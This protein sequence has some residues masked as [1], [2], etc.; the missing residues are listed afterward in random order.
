MDERSRSDGRW[1]ARARLANVG[2]VHPLQTW[3][4]HMLGDVA[5]ALGVV[6]LGQLDAW[7][8]SLTG[9]HLSGSPAA[10][11]GFYLA[12]ALPLAAR[13][14]FP[15]AVGLWVAGVLLLQFLALGASAGNGT[16][17]PALVAS[18]T[19]GAHVEPPW[20]YAGVVAAIVV[21]FVHELRN[22]NLPTL[23]AL[24]RAVAWDTTFV[25][26]WLLGAYLRT[27][28][29]Y[30]SELHDRAV[31]AEHDRAEEARAAVV[32]ERARIA[33]ELHDAIAH[34]VSVMVVQAEAAA[35]VIAADPV[36]ARGALEK[37]QRSGRDALAELRRMVGVLRTDDDAPALAPEPGL[38]GL[39]SLVERVRASGV[40]VEIRVDGDAVALPPALDLSAYRIVQEALTNTLKHAG[41]AQA[42]ISVRYRVDNVVLEICDNGRGAAGANGGGHGLAGMRERVAFFGGELETGGR[43]DGGFR[44]CAMLPLEPR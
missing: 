20:A 13:R 29:L 24:A 27:R 26:A 8:P 30:V 16:L 42:E 7:R 12:A 34:G 9:A 31:R 38:A 10:V 6:A 37:I 1:R 33:R 4:K 14:R 23:H 41:P 2:R 11:A 28:R 36:A 39:E 21:P 3:P 15:L 44:V 40:P 43:A 35:E 17:L 18:Y 22:P 32:Q 5:L 19:I 25:A